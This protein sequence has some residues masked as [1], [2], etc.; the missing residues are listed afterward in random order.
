MTYKFFPDEEKIYTGYTR[1]KNGEPLPPKFE[2]TRYDIKMKCPRCN[3][4][5]KLDK[6]VVIYGPNTRVE[7][8]S[9]SDMM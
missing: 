9:S 8:E 1:M 7:S 3:K 2:E 5:L 6:P 4:I